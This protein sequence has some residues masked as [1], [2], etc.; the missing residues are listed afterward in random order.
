MVYLALLKRE[1]KHPKVTNEICSFTL[2]YGQLRY[3]YKFRVSSL[4]NLFRDGN[5]PK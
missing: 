2:R 1:Q 4:D 5:N 3:I